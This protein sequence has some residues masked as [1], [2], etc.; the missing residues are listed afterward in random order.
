MI[1]SMKSK[2]KGKEKS[3]ANSEAKNKAKSKARNKAKNKAMNKAKKQRA[4]ALQI[5]SAGACLEQTVI[6]TI[7][8]ALKK[9]RRT[10][11]QG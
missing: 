5:N 4:M 8:Y 3:K 10:R 6:H 2:A 1:S 7:I 11:I 9:A